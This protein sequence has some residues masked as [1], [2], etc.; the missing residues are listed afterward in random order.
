MSVLDDI[1]SGDYRLYELRDPETDEYREQKQITMQHLES[2]R[3]DLDDKQK[4][5]LEEYL[6][7]AYILNGIAL[8]EYYK[9]GAK[10]GAQLALELLDIPCTRSSDGEQ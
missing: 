3:A 2:F 5:Q 8:T 1:L 10:F 7:N 9:Q 4:M 6:S